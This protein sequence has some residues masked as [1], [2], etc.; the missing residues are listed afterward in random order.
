MH[1]HNTNTLLWRSKRHFALGK[2]AAMII[3]PWIGTKMSLQNLC[4]SPILGLAHID[5]DVDLALLTVKIAIHVNGIIT[6][7]LYIYIV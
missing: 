2:A 4:S 5:V 7:Y 1:S 6:L 3:S